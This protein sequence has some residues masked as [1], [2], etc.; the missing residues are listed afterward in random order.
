MTS[1]FYGSLGA[2]LFGAN[3]NASVLSSNNKRSADIDEEPRAY[4]GA[5]S[6]SSSSSSSCVRSGPKVARIEEWPQTSSSSSSSSSKLLRSA[7]LK[8]PAP[9]TGSAEDIIKALGGDPLVNGN[10]DD[11]FDDGDDEKEGDALAL[12]PRKNRRRKRKA[13]YIPPVAQA[14]NNADSPGEM[15]T[16]ASLAVKLRI[17]KQQAYP[18][19][20]RL[21]IGVL[22]LKLAADG[23]GRGRLHVPSAARIIFQNPQVGRKYI[24]LVSRCMEMGRNEF[25]HSERKDLFRSFTAESIKSVVAEKFGKAEIERLRAPGGGRKVINAGLHEDLFDLFLHLRTLGTKTTCTFMMQIAMELGKQ[26][27]D[28]GESVPVITRDWVTRWALSYGLALRMP[29]S[30]PKLSEEEAASRVLSTWKTSWSV[31][32]FLRRLG[33]GV[34]IR[35]LDEKPLFMNS[36]SEGKILA[37][38]GSRTVTVCE[39][40]GRRGVD[41]RC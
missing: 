10:E 2:Q 18:F 21:Y 37:Q 39:H 14:V 34:R 29:N 28:K 8:K 30:R 35:A 15:P 40:M 19:G 5:A 23:K 9:E 11:P 33:Y 26:K 41:T 27:R 22:A 25:S 24:D 6:S 13:Q 7:P 4:P 36:T 12:A 16:I 1:N 20:E 3:Y 38:S 17:K 31:L 32:T